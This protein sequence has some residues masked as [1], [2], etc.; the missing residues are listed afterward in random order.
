M[1]HPLFHYKWSGRNTPLFFYSASRLQ[2]RSL[3]Q[4]EEHPKV[5]SQYDLFHPPLQSALDISFDES[6]FAE[7]QASGD[8]EF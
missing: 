6:C 1:V 7:C 8:I 2:N 3:A 4:A 5:S